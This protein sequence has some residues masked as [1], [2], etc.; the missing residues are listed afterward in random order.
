MCC[1]PCVKAQRAVWPASQHLHAVVSQSPA[2]SALHSRAQLLSPSKAFGCQSSAAYSSALSASTHDMHY[3]HTRT[4]RLH[5]CSDGVV[6]NQQHR[7]LNQ[8]PACVG[9]HVWRGPLS[10]SL[11]GPPAV[12]TAWPRGLA[13]AADPPLPLLSS[14][15]CGSW[16][17]GTT[18]S[19]ATRTGAWTLSSTCT[20]WT[21]SERAAACLCCASGNGTV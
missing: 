20:P 8:R 15:A 6:L 14:P 5:A 2:S 13:A 9:A 12:V 17:P 16:C 1:R 18:T 4:Q 21:T 7:A 3:T 19:G 11:D 10:F